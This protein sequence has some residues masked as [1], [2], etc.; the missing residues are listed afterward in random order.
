MDE[1][2][3]VKPGAI[4]ITREPFG[5]ILQFQEE[6]QG[7]VEVVTEMRGEVQLVP[8]R[9][10]PAAR[11]DPD[12]TRGPVPGAVLAARSGRLAAVH[13]LQ[14]LLDRVDQEDHLLETDNSKKNL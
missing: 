11:R 13:V 6:V 3:I 12:L 7:A 5:R 2:P 14:E 8:L 1:S 9:A 4:R 10:D